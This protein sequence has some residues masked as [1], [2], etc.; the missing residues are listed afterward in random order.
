MH[1]KAT[2]KP[3]HLL[4]TIS[5]AILTALCLIPVWLI[6]FPAMQ[7]YPQHLFLSHVVNTFND[8]S[9]NWQHYQVDF[10]FGPYALFYIVMKVLSLAF[11]PLVA[12]KIFISIYLVLIPILIFLV[13]PRDNEYSPWGMLLLFPL[14]FHQMYFMGFTNYIFSIPLLIFALHTHGS[15]TESPF[16]PKAALIHVLLLFILFLCHPYTILVYITLSLAASL[17]HLKNYHKLLKALSSPVVT[18]II[19]ITWYTSVQPNSTGDMPLLWWPIQDVAAYY[20]MMFTGMNLSAGLN[21]LVLFMWIAATAIIATGAAFFFSKRQE[22]F[23]WVFF[24]FFLLST[25]GFFA[26]PFWAGKY[27]YFNLRLAPVSYFFAAIL[28]GWCLIPRPA[29]LIIFCVAAMLIVHSAKTQYL[30]SKETAQIL[31]ILA[32][33]TK[34]AKILPMVFDK[35]SEVLDQKFFPEA[36]AHDYFYYHITVGGGASPSLFPSPMLPVK[37][38][39]NAHLPEPIHDFAWQDHGAA[40][41]YLLTRGAPQGFIPF[42]NKYA[43]TLEQSG[44]WVLLKNKTAPTR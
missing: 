3:T 38:Q 4:F 5:V 40:Y 33:M 15:L 32:K 26:L 39:K 29:G 14:S 13:K 41:H 12:G 21:W 8:P 34:N 24:L 35:K 25:I 2:C 30:F 10:T 31:P 42:V 1:N 17:L 44:P 6:S 18:A 9:F 27:S 36:H 7:D 16:R 20:M 22:P 28:A 43:H 37:F 23:P 11:S 19:F